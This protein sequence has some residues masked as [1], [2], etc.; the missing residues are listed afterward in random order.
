METEGFLPVCRQ[1]NDYGLIGLGCQ[2]FAGVVDAI[3]GIARSADG[4]V[5][6]EF[7]LVIGIHGLVGK[8]KVK[9]SERLIGH[10]SER[11][12]HKML[13]GQIMGLLLFAI[14]KQLPDIIEIINRSGV[15]ISMGFTLPEGFFVELDTFVGHSSENHG[16][17]ATVADG[18]GFVPGFGRLIV[19]QSI[20]G[21]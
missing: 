4:R 21:C 12:T 5:K 10:L 19:E 2:H 11:D 20:V 15:F 13:H 9:I 17:E 6:I 7:A 16:T 14:K 1:V 18:K 8:F 3:D